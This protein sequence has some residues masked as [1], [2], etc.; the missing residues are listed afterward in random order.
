MYVSAAP[1]WKRTLSSHNDSK[2]NILQRYL[3]SDNEI[4]RLEIRMRYTL[5]VFL[6]LLEADYHTRTCE[7]LKTV[8]PLRHLELYTKGWSNEK[9]LA[10]MQFLHGETEDGHNMFPSNLRNCWKMQTNCGYIIQC[11]TR[12]EKSLEKHV[13]GG[14]TYE[15][16]LASSSW[17]RCDHI[18]F[19]MAVYRSVKCQRKVPGI[20]AWVRRSLYPS[21]KHF[22]P[23]L[24]LGEPISENIWGQLVLILRVRFSVCGKQFFSEW[25]TFLLLN[26][27]VSL[28]SLTLY[29]FQNR[30]KSCLRM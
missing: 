19:V 27:P 13:R 6:L 4:L 28:G 3:M 16:M 14:L 8:S 23:E 18:C 11:I 15:G 26:E 17:A 2:I 22:F 9:S 29:K 1:I 25:K 20:R 10:F 30:R 24:I 7:S 5:D 12:G 21:T